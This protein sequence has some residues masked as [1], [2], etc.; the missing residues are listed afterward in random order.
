MNVA[1][2]FDDAHRF[3]LCDE[4]AL[5]TMIDGQHESMVVDDET[6]ASN[7]PCAGYVAPGSDESVCLKEVMPPE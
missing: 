5:H 1:F 6:E 4:C 7:E 2:I 3:V